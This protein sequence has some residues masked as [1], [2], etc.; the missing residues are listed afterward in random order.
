LDKA[1][2]LMSKAFNGQVQI[3]TST[4]PQALPLIDGI[5][6]TIKS[7]APSYSKLAGDINTLVKMTR[8]K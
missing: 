3:L 5:K 2:E 8:E 6:A 4:N 7:A 1:K